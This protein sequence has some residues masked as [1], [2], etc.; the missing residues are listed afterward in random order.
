MGNDVKTLIYNKLFSKQCEE[1]E[2]HFLFDI[3]DFPL[4]DVSLTPDRYRLG[5][6][7]MR[8]YAE[9]VINLRALC[10]NKAR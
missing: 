4:S 9:R 7:E 6:E 8:S 3:D 5:K 2:K 1:G 10:V